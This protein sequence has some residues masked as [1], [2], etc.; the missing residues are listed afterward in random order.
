MQDKALET[1]ILDLAHRAG[2]DGAHVYEVNKSV[3]TNELNAYATGIGDNKRIVLWDTIIK[4]FTPDELLMTMG[5]EMGHYVLNH[6]W[7]G[8]FFGSLVLLL[9]LYLLH[10]SAGWVLRRFSSRTGVTELSDVASLPLLILLFSVFLFMFQP[11]INAYSR[12]LEHEADRFGLEI[13]H[14]NHACG[15]VFAKFAEHDL[16]YPTPG[17]LYVLWR[18][19]HPPLGERIQF[20]NDYH[21]WTE[22]KPGEYQQY[23]QP[24]NT[25]AH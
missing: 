17:P 10:R 22:G 11:V 7:K 15:M 8:I 5:H 19:D 12:H 24:A 1:R 13:T 25:P 4:Q 14:L 3:D 21:P 23:F 6:V 18:S 2:I 16:A 9:G 20:C